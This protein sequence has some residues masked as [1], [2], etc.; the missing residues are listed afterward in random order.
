VVLV[1]VVLVPV[2]LVPVVPVR[3]VLVPAARLQRPRAWLVQEQI[4]CPAP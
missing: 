4:R 2:V 3:V 1:P